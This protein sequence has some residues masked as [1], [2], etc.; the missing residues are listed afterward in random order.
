L[1]DAKV[2]AP[3]FLAA[4]LRA[5]FLPAGF[6]EPPFFV[7]ADIMAASLSTFRDSAASFFWIAASFFCRAARAFPRFLFAPLPGG[8]AF[9]LSFIFSPA[10]ASSYR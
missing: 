6:D 8:T 2:F 4:G 7:F 9:A 10:I 3:G 1:A 5:G